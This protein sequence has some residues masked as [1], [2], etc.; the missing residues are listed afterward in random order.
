[1]AGGVATS[2]NEATLVSFTLSS[3]AH[4]STAVQNADGTY[5]TV[6]MEYDPVLARTVIKAKLTSFDGE[7]IRDTFVLS[8]TAASGGG[9]GNPTVTTLPDGRFIV[10]YSSSDGRIYTSLLSPQG[11]PLGETQV[12]AIITGSP[13]NPEVVPIATGASAGGYMVVWEGNGDIKA[14]IYNASGQKVGGEFRFNT[15]A[16]PPGGRVVESGV[17]T[18]TLTDGR[19]VVVYKQFS[20]GVDPETGDDYSVL[21]LRYRIINQDGSIG[22]EINLPTATESTDVNV[23]ALAGGRYLITW[24][25]GPRT[26]ALVYNSNGSIANDYFISPENTGTEQ[27][28]ITA[29]LPGDFIAVA[30]LDYNGSSFT[31]RAKV[32]NIDGSTHRLEFVVATGV[33]DFAPEVI[34]H[35]D[36]RFT[37]TWRT[38]SGA[39]YTQTWDTRRTGSDGWFNWSGSDAA[40]DSYVGTTNSD[41]L[42]GGGGHDRLSGYTGNDSL[43]GGAGNDTLKGGSGHDTLNG[44]DGNDILYGDSDASDVLR[45][46]AGDDTYYIHYRGIEAGHQIE[47]DLNQQIGGTDKAYIYRGDFATVDDIKS[48]RAFLTL[49]G[50]E[51]VIVADNND[52]TNIQFSDSFVREHLGSELNVGV[53][54]ALDTDGDTLTWQLIDDANGIVYLEGAEIKVKDHTKLDFEQLET[55]DFTFTV[56]VTDGLG[57]SFEK[58]FTVAVENIVTERVT[59]TSGN[60]AIKG[61]GGKDRLTGG[62]GNDTLSGGAETDTLT[63]GAGEDVFLFDSRFAS[64]NI[65]TISNFEVS[66]DKIHL[67]RDIFTAFAESDVG[68]NLDINA[69]VIGTTALST[70]DRIIYDPQSGKLFYDSDGSGGVAARHFAT[71]GLNLNLNNGHF[72]IV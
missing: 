60:D 16:S 9:L 40:N 61:G 11:F 52:P 17:Q 34:S 62:D 25:E 32:L 64:S 46:G 18:A 41:R 51:S 67:E 19:S 15:P 50:I 8:S 36:G 35:N 69:F 70:E 33:G 39:L 10:S 22:A 42:S 31:L 63:G 66:A 2:W 13:Q 65:D 23:S 57:N 1:M 56:R 30:W 5:T 49:R 12:N 14:Q 28:P 44:D 55:R 4:P 24:V 59:G 45:G 53:L 58:S 3:Q 43:T 37:I 27:K 54:S 68:K 6:W 72:F 21:F 48:Y 38:D 71:L 20:E 7:V 26:R 29:V 47:E